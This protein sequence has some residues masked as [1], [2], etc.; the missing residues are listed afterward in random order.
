PRLRDLAVG[1][2]KEVVLVEV[3][4][5]WWDVG[6]VYPV[7]AEGPEALDAPREE[8]GLLRVLD[9]ELENLALGLVGYLLDLPDQSRPQDLRLDE[10]VTPQPREFI[11]VVGG[12]EDRGRRSMEQPSYLP[13]IEP[14]PHD[15]LSRLAGR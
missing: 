13:V 1:E 5:G 15:H 6:V 3:R 10:P 8:L 11:P 9:L 14:P 2:R 7:E 4:L 12:H